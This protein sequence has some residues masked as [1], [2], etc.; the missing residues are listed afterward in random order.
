MFKLFSKLLAFALL[1]AASLASDC[2]NYNDDC[3][4]CIQYSNGNFFRCSFCP[5]DGICHAV[6]SV[7]NK[8]SSDE[9][10]SLSEASSCKMNTAADCD[11]VKYGDMRIVS[12]RKGNLK[13]SQ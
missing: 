2:N 8:C 7:F 1:F 12:E 11:N 10:V 9:C 3:L 5:V 6:G 13:G 4:S